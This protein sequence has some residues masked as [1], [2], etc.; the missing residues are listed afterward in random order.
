MKK[1]GVLLL[2]ILL[3][4]LCIGGC[5]FDP[6]DYWGQDRDEKDQLIKVEIFFTDDEQLTGY[7]KNLG[8]EKDGTVYVGGSS[9]NYLYDKNGNIVGSFNYQRVLYMKII[10][11]AKTD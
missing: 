7:V 5:D 3:I 8:I 6:R 9:L 4:A 10:N 2:F 11:E 1:K